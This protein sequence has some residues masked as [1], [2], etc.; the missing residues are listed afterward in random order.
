MVGCVRE[1]TAPRPFRSIHLPLNPPPQHPPQRGRAAPAS[2][3]WGRWPRTA[4]TRCTWSGRAAA[5]ERWRPAPRPRARRS[6]WRLDVF[7]CVGVGGQVCGYE[8]L[9]LICT[10]YTYTQNR[11]E[12]KRTHLP[13]PCTFSQTATQRPHLMHLS[14]SSQMALYVLFGFVWSL[15]GW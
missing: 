5:P 6:R 9:I 10:Y 4:R 12:S 14:W 11:K 3:P 7:V 1:C 2:R 8:R 13:M 15:V